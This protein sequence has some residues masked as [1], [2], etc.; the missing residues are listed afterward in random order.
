[1]AVPPQR[2]NTIHDPE[3]RQVAADLVATSQHDVSDA[4]SFSE[5]IGRRAISVELHL[6]ERVA[7]LMDGMLRGL[8][9]EDLFYPYIR[10][11]FR[12][13][14][15]MEREAQGF[16]SQGSEEYRSVY[17]AL[18]TDAEVISL[19]NRAEGHFPMPRPGSNDVAEFMKL[20]R[21]EG[22]VGL[23]Q[24]AASGRSELLG[25]YAD[26]SRLMAGY[27]GAEHL[28]GPDFLWEHVL[29]NAAAV[30]AFARAY[31]RLER[32]AQFRPR[33]ENV[34]RGTNTLISDLEP[35][36]PHRGLHAIRVNDL[37]EL[38]PCGPDPLPQQPE[39]AHTT[40]KWQGP[41]RLFTAC[42]AVP[43]RQAGSI[44]SRENEVARGYDQMRE[45]L[46]PLS[47]CD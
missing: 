18:S 17:D 24:L 23:E 46:L 41:N 9:L 22:L 34:T 10:E 12:A 47:P 15:R 35:L 21:L 2:L 44:S 37:S 30:C 28:H 43:E 36:W 8:P 3:I 32:N 40:A 5:L 42:P 31:C 1:M 14:T 11:A 45:I 25:L 29:D 4:K 33:T 20:L 38:M 7:P 27:I 26:N 13:S 39:L 19:N 16:G 6:R